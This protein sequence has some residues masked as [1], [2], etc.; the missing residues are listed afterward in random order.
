MISMPRLQAGG[1]LARLAALMTF[2]L[3]PLGLI[4]LYQTNAVVEEATRLS[5]ASL[6]DRTERAAARER[7]LLQRAGGAT[8]GVAAAIL[9]VFEDR[10]ACGI[11]L[12]AFTEGQN[13]FTFAAFITP[14]GRMTCASDGK[15]RDVSERW[16]YL[17][18]RQASQLS[19]ALGRNLLGEGGSF[20]LAT[21]P[22]QRD[23]I[24]LGYVSIAIPH[25]VSAVRSGKNWS[26]RG[27]QFVT[28]DDQGEILSSSVPEQQAAQVLP[29]S[30]PRRDLLDRTGETFFEDDRSGDERFFA[31]TEIL[32]GQ[33][34]VVGSWPV[35]N[36]MTAARNP[37]SLMTVAF[38]VL[39]WL[40]GISV[41]LLG[42]QQMVIRHLSALR[43]AMR[44]YA[45]GEREDPKLELINP[46]REFEEA[47]Q[48]FNRMVVILSEAERRRELDLEEKT[49]L[50]R[51]VHHRVKN[52]LQLVASIMNM[53]GRSAQTPEARRMLSQLQRRVRGLAT[54]HRNLNT[55]PDITTV[56]SR[57]L[58]QELI[59]EIGSMNAGTGQE[60]VIEADLAPVPLS[61]DQGVTLSMLVSEAMTNAVKYLG[62]PE[63]GRPRIDVRL[64]ETAENWLELEIT[65]TKGQ[66]LVTEGDGIQGTGIGAR[67]MMAFAAQ[68]DG[69]ASTHETETGYTY[70]LGFPVVAGAVPPAAHDKEQDHDAA[71][72]A[73]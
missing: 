24:L 62:V 9:P 14:E 68:L 16:M 11:L 3:L 5:H 57:D 1:L 7:E 47:Q 45:L 38:P 63:G 40:A 27:I 46:P 52:N 66:P 35:E 21:S 2:A 33:V 32:P 48:S 49:V 28:V 23:G 37:A 69:T 60:I 43:R 22:V 17:K 65:N 26:D 34:S 64:H 70:R 51:E 20:L 25:K 42:L 71:E 18:A 4:A 36:A 59:A 12:R 72:P 30:V 31:V 39:M 29:V 56:D 61:Q 10:R 67:L 55:N 54:I 41:A 13:P 58:I 15:V 6:L 50:L 44:R 19:F 73:V 53:Q 8:E